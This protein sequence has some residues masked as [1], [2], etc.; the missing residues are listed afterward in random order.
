[1]ESLPADLDTSRVPGSL[2]SATEAGGHIPG[3]TK[4]LTQ[5]VLR[6]RQI[7]LL[8]LI[9]RPYMAAVATLSTD[10]QEAAT[11]SVPIEL[12]DGAR[13]HA[14]HAAQYI[15]KQPKQL[16]RHYGAWLLARNIWTSAL[17]LL[18][19]LNTPI[20]IRHIE[21]KDKDLSIDGQAPEQFRARAL[22]AA[23]KAHELI[24]QWRHESKGLAFCADQLYSLLL[25]KQRKVETPESMGGP[26]A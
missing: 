17:S 7:Q 12:L 3:T 22:R 11:A 9:F 24:Q 20:L 26:I 18:A 19:T 8:M 14:T 10:T 5:H 16:E 1:M 4:R 23:T 13:F 21:Y 6:N 25:N 2:R 15:E